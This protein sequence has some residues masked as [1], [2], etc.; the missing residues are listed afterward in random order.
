MLHMLYHV[1]YVTNADCWGLARHV[2]VSMWLNRP[3][4]PNMKHRMME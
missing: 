2:L 1:I 4:G 3:V